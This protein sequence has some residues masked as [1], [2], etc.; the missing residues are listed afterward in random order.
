MMT[1][2]NFYAAQN[3]TWKI[4]LHEFI[5]DSYF[6]FLLNFFFY[7]WIEPDIKVE[8]NCKVVIL[9]QLFAYLDEFD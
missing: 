4:T 8:W 5:M 6:S 2:C 3:Q 7:T 1:K 9:I